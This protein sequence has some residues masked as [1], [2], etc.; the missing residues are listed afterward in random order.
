MTD[1]PSPDLLFDDQTELGRIRAEATFGL[2]EV[3]PLIAALKP[4]ARILEIGCGTGYLLARLSQL[5][6]DLAFVGLEPIG[7]GFMKFDQTLRRIEG[8]F[9]N[10]T[11]I[12]APIE[13]FRP[14]GDDAGF[15]L[16]FAVNVFEHLADWR[17]ALVR[18]AALLATGGRLVILCP[19]YLVPYE[20]H[21]AIPVL[22]SPV[23]TRRVFARH[24]EAVEERL[25]AQGLWESLNFITATALRREAARQGLHF[26]FDRGIMARMLERLQSDPEFAQRQAGVAKV[27]RLLGRLGAGHVLRRIPAGFS[28]YM[29]AILH[30]G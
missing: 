16:V 30:R 1:T 13:A 18:A 4:G 3:G 9:P 27:A 24:I 7:K 29:K 25:S 17:I 2:N 10:V 15:D 12:R 21:F 20:P 5:R 6:P 8:S 26:E 19:N 28:P 22:G 14:H 23:L 11:I